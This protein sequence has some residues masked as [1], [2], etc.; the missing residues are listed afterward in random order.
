MLPL[1]YR[2]SLASVL[3]A[4]L[5]LSDP[6]DLRILPAFPAVCKSGLLSSLRWCQ[7]RLVVLLDTLSVKLH[8]W[9][10]NE[11]TVTSGAVTS[12]KALHGVFDIGPIYLAEFKWRPWSTVRLRTSATLVSAL[13]SL[14]HGTT[15]GSAYGHRRSTARATLKHNLGQPNPCPQVHC[16]SRTPLNSI[17]GPADKIPIRI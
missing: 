17:L 1:L 7:R 2:H 8:E 12:I 9:Q 13:Y 11:V 5:P 4:F 6:L 16:Q 15:A 14:P 3:P 10:K